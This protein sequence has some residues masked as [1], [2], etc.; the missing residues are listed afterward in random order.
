MRAAASG[1][2][3]GWKGRRA[4]VLPLYRVKVV[5]AGGGRWAS[6]FR[7][8][9]GWS[10]KPAI[11]TACQNRNR[12]A[13]HRLPPMVSHAVMVTSLVPK[14]QAFELPPRMPSQTS[15]VALRDLPSRISLIV[16]PLPIP[17][18]TRSASRKLDFPLAFVPMN[19]LSRPSDRSIRRRLLKSSIMMRAITSPPPR[20][21]PRAVRYHTDRS[22]PP[23]HQLR[24]A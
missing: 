23:A 12:R 14:K 24:R 17:C 6:L 3:A 15:L 19:R 9:V 20:S 18:R 8:K 4:P 22:R 10:R 21:T 1:V 2:R 13:P 11:R 16:N 5:M 7:S